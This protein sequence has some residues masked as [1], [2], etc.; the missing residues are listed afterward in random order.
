[1]SATKVECL[2][3][4]TAGQCCSIPFTYKGVKYASCTTANHNRLWC[5]LDATYKGKWGNCG[6]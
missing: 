3:K 4:T 1:M 5:S 6:K 2:S